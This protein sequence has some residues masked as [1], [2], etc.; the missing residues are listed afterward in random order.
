MAGSPLSTTISPRVLVTLR[1]RGAPRRDHPRL[2]SSKSAG[3]HELESSLFWPTNPTTSSVAARVR[4]HK[5]SRRR[6]LT[7]F[8]VSTYVPDS[9]EPHVKHDEIADLFRRC[10]VACGCDILVVGT[11]INSTI[12]VHYRNDDADAPDRVHGPCG[13]PDD[14]FR[15]H[16]F[17]T[18]HALYQ[19]ALLTT[20]FWQKC[21]R[22][23]Q[24]WGKNRHA[25]TT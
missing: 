16:E 21:P 18:I 17:Y 19:L 3:A 1:A 22:R 7:M 9:G 25:Q 20:Y 11:D 6:P 15:R 5:T 14:K 23:G 2:I 12:S 10:C 8:L 24:G 4:L 13:I